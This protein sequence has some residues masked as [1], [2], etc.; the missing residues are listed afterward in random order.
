[1]GCS[2]GWGDEDREV[3]A[4]LVAL[5][6]VVRAEEVEVGGVTMSGSPV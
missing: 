2:V 6:V 1:M 4:V 5:V 3:V